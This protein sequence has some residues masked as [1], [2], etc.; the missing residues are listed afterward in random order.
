ML[1]L[2]LSGSSESTWAQSGLEGRIS[3]TIDSLVRVVNVLITG[4]VVWSGF[5][6]AKGD[7]HGFQR[8]IYGI[9]GLIVANTSYM[10]INYF[11]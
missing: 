1:A 7:Q 3:Q 5:L 11:S 6:I 2:T 8:L 4:F 9:V 10:I